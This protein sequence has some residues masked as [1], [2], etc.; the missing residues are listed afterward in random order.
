MAISLRKAITAAFFIIV[1]M[2]LGTVFIYASWGKILHPGQ[3]AQAV[4]NYQI[5][6]AALVNPVALILPW[7]EMV[8]GIGL[9]IG[10]IA[11]GSALIVAGL[12]MIFIVALGYSLIRGLD[13]QCGCFSLK[14]QNSAPLYLDMLRDLALLAMALIT[15]GHPRRKNVIT[16]DGV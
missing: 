8:C 2:A 13:I 3:F 1:R 7:L 11:R 4:A 5:L 6:P 15:M 10:L 12:M 14:V 9:L 16:M